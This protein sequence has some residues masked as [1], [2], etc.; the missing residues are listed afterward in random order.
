M[1]RMAGIMIVMAVGCAD[2]QLLTGPTREEQTLSLYG[3]VSDTTL[4]PIEGARIEVVDGQRANEVAITDR[5]GRYELPGLFS[6]P[7]TV[8]ASKQ[9][10]APQTKTATSNRAS[11]DVSFWLD[12]VRNH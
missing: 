5:S 4:S 7:T 10:Y 12:E 8:R 9:G 11:Q 2:R 1:W 6:A 3:W